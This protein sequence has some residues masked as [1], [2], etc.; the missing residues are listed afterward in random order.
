MLFY[1]KDKDF[2]LCKCRNLKSNYANV[3]KVRLCEC[4]VQNRIVDKDFRLYRCRNLK[5]SYTNVVKVNESQ[6]V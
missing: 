4:N 3:V 5:S 1:R 6:V 2:R